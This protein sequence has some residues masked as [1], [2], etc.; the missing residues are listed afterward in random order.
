MSDR[1]SLALFVLKEDEA[2]RP[3]EDLLDLIG[4]IKVSYSSDFVDESGQVIPVYE[5]QWVTLWCRA[6]TTVISNYQEVS[7]YF[8]TNAFYALP[9]T[10]TSQNP[11]AQAFISACERLPIAAAIVSRFPHEA[12]EETVVHAVESVRTWNSVSLVDRDYAA[13]YLERDLVFWP[14]NPWSDY[15]E[16]LQ[17]S[18]GV[19]VFDHPAGEYWN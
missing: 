18:T 1:N 3:L 4:C 17:L 19:V 6:S 13:L 14:G 9:K 7:L 8:S 16:V 15:R 2:A 11:L 12:C 10:P 5:C